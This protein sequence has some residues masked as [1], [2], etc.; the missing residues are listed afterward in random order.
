MRA[1]DQL[2]GGRVPG[3]DPGAPHRLLLTFVP[4]YG[5]DG[6]PATYRAAEIVD[7]LVKETKGAVPIFGG[8]SSAGLDPET[9][10]ARDATVV[11]HYQQ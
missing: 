10:S 2:G 5:P 11:E 6:D 4:G 7:A 8:V 1:A 3:P 9:A